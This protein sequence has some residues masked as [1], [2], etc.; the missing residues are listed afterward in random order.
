MNT[1]TIEGC[2]SPTL[3]NYERKCEREVDAV[4]ALSVLLCEIGIRTSSLALPTLHTLK[5]KLAWPTSL[6]TNKPAFEMHK[7]NAH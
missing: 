2:S 6:R 1:V 5:T 7:P 3:S 4:Y